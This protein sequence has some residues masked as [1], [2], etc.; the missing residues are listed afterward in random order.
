ALSP[1]SFEGTVGS[2]AQ[3]EPTVVVTDRSGNPVPNVTVAFSFY[4]QAETAVAPIRR[5]E[6]LTNQQGI[7]SAGEWTL[8]NTAGP[9]LLQATIIGAPQLW[10]V[11]NG[12]PDT[13][14]ALVWMKDNQ[15]EI[16]FAGMVLQP[17]RV[18]VG[19]RF[20]NSVLG[21]HVTFDIT[22]GGGALEGAVAVTDDHGASAVA[23]T[24]GATPGPNTLSARV[25]GLP[26][27]DFTIEVVAASAIYDLTMI[28]DEPLD[29]WHIESAFIAFTD[30]GRFV[31]QVTWNFG[32]E[33]EVW[34]ES[35]SYTMSGPTVVL[36]YA[37]HQDTGALANGVLVL[38]RWDEEGPTRQWRYYIRD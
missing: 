24:L 15:G 8:G 17:P 20:G 7:A 32:E 1:T 10:F 19:D 18:L 37:G 23:W 2:V 4:G 33:R 22:A 9:N 25:P 36:E 3:Q 12:L 30:D 6:V 21:I 27:I 38:D 13:P 29:W 31:S 14:V 11:A 16:G 35:G 26:S 28:D 34:T 5:S